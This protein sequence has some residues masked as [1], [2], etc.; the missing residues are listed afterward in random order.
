MSVLKLFLNAL[1][2]GISRDEAGRDKRS[3]DDPGNG[4]ISIPI[5]LNREILYESFISVDSMVF[6]FEMNQF[7]EESLEEFIKKTVFTAEELLLENPSVFD[8]FNNYLEEV[9]GVEKKLKDALELRNKYFA[10]DR[11]LIGRNL[12]AKKYK[13]LHSRTNGHLPRLY[14]ENKDKEYLQMMKRLISA[15]YEEDG[16]YK[17]INREMAEFYGERTEIPK[18]FVLDSRVSL[19]IGGS[20]FS[21]GILADLFR[22]LSVPNVSEMINRTVPRLLAP[23][24]DLV[25]KIHLKTSTEKRSQVLDFL[26]SC[27]ERKDSPFKEKIDRAFEERTKILEIYL[28]G[29]PKARQKLQ[30]LDKLQEDEISKLIFVFRN[31]EDDDLS[32]RIDKPVVKTYIDLLENNQKSTKELLYSMFME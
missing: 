17:A 9:D 22:R 19:S 31:I 14:Y 2:A 21:P 6:I 16:M 7:T 11:S 20:I 4:Q 24:E 26:Y 23:V 15:K 12:S 27:L 10:N 32:L 1:V 30:I 3:H 25:S 8:K 18:S 13:S 5:N 29:D 28:K